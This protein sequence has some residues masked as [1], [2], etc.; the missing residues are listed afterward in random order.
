MVVACATGGPWFGPCSCSCSFPCSSPGSCPGSG[1]GS[2]SGSGPGSGPR[3]SK[4]IVQGPIHSPRFW[5]FCGGPSGLMGVALLVVISQGHESYFFFA[6]IVFALER[7]WWLRGPCFGLKNIF[8]AS[9]FS[10][11]LINVGIFIFLSMFKFFID[12]FIC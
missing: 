10:C 7:W 2:G 11:G 8:N 3:L 12:T 5:I 9:L 6:T 1:S 4:S